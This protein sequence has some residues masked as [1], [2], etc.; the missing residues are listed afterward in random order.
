MLC[1]RVGVKVRIRS[2][3][4]IDPTSLDDGLRAIHTLTR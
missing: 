3:A 4:H 1:I 2:V